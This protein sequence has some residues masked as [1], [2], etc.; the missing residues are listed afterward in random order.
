MNPKL[1][2]CLIVRD[3]EE[4]LERCLASVQGLGD[5]MVVVDTGSTDRTIEIARRFGAH[6]HQFEWCDD[7]AA[8][9]NCSFDLASGDYILWLDA[10]DVLPEESR[11]Q[12]LA[13]KPSLNRDVYFLPYDYAQDEFGRSTCTL[14]RE[15]LVRN[16]PTIR[17]VGE[18]HEHLKVA[19]RESE[20]LEI[21]IKHLRTSRG[22]AGDR[23]RNLRILERAA[24]KPGGSEDPRTAY[25]LARELDDAG[26]TARAV[27]AYERYLALPSA[28]IEDRFTA[29]C[30]LG[31]AARRMAMSEAEDTLHWRA[32][33]RQAAKQAR[34]CMPE[35]A[36]PFCLLGDLALDE[37][38]P[39]EAVFWYNQAVR[40]LP[41]LLGPVLPADYL[42]R[43]AVQLCLAYD[44]MGETQLANDWNER[45]LAE[46][47]SDPNLVYNRR[48]LSAK[49]PGTSAAARPE[50][51]IDIV[52]ATFHA[53]E[54]LEACLAS[55]AACTR[56]PHRIIVVAAGLQDPPFA[57]AEN[58]TWIRPETPLAFAAAINR[59]VRE[60][61]SPCLCF[62]ND[63]T[64]VSR[65]WLEP[66][67]ESVRQTPGLA[68]PLSNCDKG[69]LHEYDL[70]IEGVPLAPGS[71]MLDGCAI[72]LRSDPS[73]CFTAERAWSYSP[74]K[75]R[76]QTL[77]WVPF[78]CT[79]LPRA[80]YNQVG[81]LDEGFYNLCEDVD[82]GMRAAR[83]GFPSMVDERSFVLHFG[84]ISRALRPEK[85]EDDW[86]RRRLEAK[87]GKPLLVIHTGHAFEAWNGDSLDRE[88]IG[89][90]E[91]AAARLAEAFVRR[92]Y[93]VVVF[94]DCREGSSAG[95]DYVHLE[96]F[97]SFAA[98]FHID[99]FIVSRYAQVLLQPVRATQRYFWA[100]DLRAI[101]A[102]GESGDVL[103][104]RAGDLDAIFC[105]SPTHREAFARTHDLDAR[106]IVITRN[107]LSPE[108][109]RGSEE[110][111][112][113]RFIYSSSPDRGLDTL[114]EL[115][116]RIR[117]RLP[118]AELQIF[119]GFDNW[120]RA[121]RLRDDPASAA[122][123]DRIRAA[124]Q[125]PGVFFRGRV[126]QQELAREMMRSDIWFYPTRFEETYC[127]TA[128]EAQMAGTVC[129]A[130]DIGALRTT[131]ADRG[132]LIGGDAYSEQYRQQAIESV[133]GLLENREHRDALAAK[134]R[135]WA[136]RQTW[137]A[138]A[139]EW[140]ATFDRVKAESGRSRTQ[141][142]G[143]VILK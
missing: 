41:K 61:K 54:Y 71:L 58:V 76:K 140:Q 24:D 40:P 8:A 43:P 13:L 129:V 31:D 116:P 96:R 11:R 69:W 90:S 22:L 15:R 87:Y 25:Y 19:D 125:Q 124:M 114:L 73:R 84:G 99:V 63:D 91:T 117:E 3:E 70:A 56:V 142:S 122:W 135:E 28:W 100:H 9:R 50:S 27:R 44:R 18:V 106:K 93:R 109:F 46:R 82:Y 20:Q 110:R 134:G 48:Y 138:V 4:V 37:N 107:G 47:P 89:G 113:F 104:R 52:I 74:G 128:L 92:G 77:D 75:T 94:G 35:R 12:L 102:W 6:V 1:S 83:L 115:F 14:Y 30:R 5:E 98:A 118:E 130:S 119:Y 45:A 16:L 136:R 126:G 17:W 112:L 39:R 53:G 79:V 36:E 51:E 33:A 57:I 65:G 67:L 121:L 86:N 133:V 108:R 88:G 23:L 143:Q 49:L 10:D 59:G 68:N 55:I 85:T 141:A 64:I 78:Y 105:L 26:E 66:L 80:V 132:V 7:F 34:A 2:V 95:V 21:V 38:D 29:M 139:E 62:L 60:G 42:V 127:I 131:V 72:R 103:N 101:P 120:D 32:R 97:A 123:R 111:Q 81:E 137:D